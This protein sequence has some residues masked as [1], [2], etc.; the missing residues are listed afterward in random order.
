MNRVFYI[1]IVSLLIGSLGLKSQNIDAFAKVKLSTNEV[2]V[3]QPVRVTISVHSSTWFADAL[4]FGN[5]NV[6]NSFIIPFT[7]T[8]SSIQYFNDKKYATLTFYYIVFPYAEG[9]IEIPALNII[10]SIPPEGDYKGQAVTIRTKARKIK[11]KPIPKSANQDNWLVA[12]NAMVWEDW[13]KSLD[14]VKVGDVIERKVFVRAFG[15]LPSFIPDVELLPTDFASQYPKDPLYID[16]RTD[17]E[18][19]GKREQTILYL[20]ESEGEFTIPAIEINWWNPW[21]KKL[22]SRKTKD[23]SITVKP[24][25]NL[26][27]LSSIKDS[28]SI[29]SD[30]VS[31]T[32][33]DDKND[34]TKY[35]SIRNGILL[36][37]GLLLSFSFV[38]IFIKILKY[39]LSIFKEYRNSEAFEFKKLRKCIRNKTNARLAF[40]GWLNKFNCISFEEL[41]V[42]KQLHLQASDTD[43][44]HRF[45]VSE[46]NENEVRQLL[47]MLD[48]IR[49]ER[50]QIT[51]SNRI[52]IN[53]I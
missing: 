37:I 22:Y 52:E 19:I 33:E 51:Q 32:I 12:D 9:D 16:Q 30:L 44:I 47:Q 34:W 43:L 15:T 41:L 50:V 40:Y 26:G 14:N 29:E 31:S 7:R 53:P 28:L 3:K 42:Q 13:S 20:F 4:D 23:I 25:P 1:L 8:V 5:L 11:V 2:Y 49:N 24:N 48:Q 36:I 38:Y 46:L 45:L 18:V 6:E 39:L 10:A 17:N 35:L 21:A 27:I